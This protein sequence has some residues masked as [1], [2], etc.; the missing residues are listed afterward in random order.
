M[1]L[2]LSVL[3]LV[4]VGV[5][6]GGLAVAVAAGQR[7]RQHTGAQDEGE[8][9]VDVDD[10]RSPGAGNVPEATATTAMM[11]TTTTV[12]TARARTYGAMS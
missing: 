2:W 9:A 6:A 8:R 7:L 4:A 3:D 5:A 10:L 12:A 1:G 11:E